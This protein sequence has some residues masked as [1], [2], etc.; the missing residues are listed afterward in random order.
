MEIIKILK[1]ALLIL[2]LAEEIRNAVDKINYVL[3]NRCV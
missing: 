1:V 3:G 2:I